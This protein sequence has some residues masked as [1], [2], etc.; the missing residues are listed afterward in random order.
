ME[1]YGVRPKAFTKAWWENYFW[2][3]Y[4][5]HTIGALFVG[6]LITIG[7]WQVVT[8]P[9]YDLQVDYISEY[10]LTDNETQMFSD[11]ITSAIDDVTEN[12]KT[13]LCFLALPMDSGSDVQQTQAI[14]IKYTTEMSYSEGYVFLMSKTYAEHSKEYGI[15]EPTSAWAGE[16]ANDGYVLSLE[17]SKALIE[18]G[19]NPAEKELYI[20]VLKM[21]D[22]EKN[23]EL[24]Q[25]R[26]QNGVKLAKFLIGEE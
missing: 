6:A 1:V 18:A 25:K 26:Y 15:F 17:N 21:R 3:H 13:E 19:I 22:K 9:K 14:Q 23:D 10:F 16:Y 4:K 11:L 24:E 5:W 2:Y 7:I 12:G 8:A 20:G